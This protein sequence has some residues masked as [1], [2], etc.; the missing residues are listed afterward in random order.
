MSLSD[1]VREELEEE[2]QQE[3]PD[4]HSVNIASVAMTT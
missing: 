2:S 1:E 4:V 3:Q